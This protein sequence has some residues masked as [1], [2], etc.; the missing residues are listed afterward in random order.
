MTGKGNLDPTGILLQTG[1]LPSSFLLSGKTR[2][3]RFEM[4]NDEGKSEKTVVLLFVYG[5]AR[6]DR[7]LFLLSV[8][9]S[10]CDGTGK[11]DLGR[12]QSVV[13]WESVCSPDQFGRPNG[14]L[15]I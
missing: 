15:S 8:P 13:I 3:W 9:L 10:R 6:T 7:V 5:S 11:I 2:F 1:P 14:R 12:C 4:W